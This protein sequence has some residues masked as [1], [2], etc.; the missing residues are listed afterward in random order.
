[1][2]DPKA[3]SIPA[4]GSMTAVGKPVEQARQQERRRHER[5]T[6]SDMATDTLEVDLE[7]FGLLWQRGRD[8]ARNV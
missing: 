5:C 4:D 1:M 3:A 2:T 8:S 6:Q 7:K